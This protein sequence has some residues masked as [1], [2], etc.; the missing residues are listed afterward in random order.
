MSVETITVALT[1]LLALEYAIDIDCEHGTESPPNAR[2]SCSKTPLINM[3][4][5][6]NCSGGKELAADIVLVRCKRGRAQLAV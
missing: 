6:L 5:L 3:Q 2:L 4:G 1:E